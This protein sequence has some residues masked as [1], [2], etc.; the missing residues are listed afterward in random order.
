MK[1]KK[2]PYEL[3]GG[4]IGL[5]LVLICRLSGSL[6]SMVPARPLILNAVGS[7]IYLVINLT[8]GLPGVFI[9]LFT[10]SKIASLFGY[11]CDVVSQRCDSEVINI[12][13]IFTILIYVVSGIII[14]RIISR[15]KPNQKNKNLNIKTRS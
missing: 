11:S 15:R 6:I 10:G 13:F 1:L 12:V 14:G 8:I 3:K 2:W 5:I 7:I 9:Y 4:L